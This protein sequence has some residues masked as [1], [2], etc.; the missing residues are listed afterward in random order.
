METTNIQEVLS[1]FDG[2][3]ECGDGK[4]M[5]CCPC[6][7]DRKQSLSIGRG[8]KGVV[9]KCHAG[10][11]THDI[12]ARV[13]IKPRD[14]FYDAE[15]KSSDRPQVVAIYNYP[16]GV[17]KLRKSDKSF[18]WR[19]PDG[20]GGYMY[21]RKGVKPSLYIAGEIS[22]AVAVVEG[23]KD[24]DSIHNVLGC[25]AVS[26]AD[27]AGPGKWRKEYTEQLRGCTALIFQDNDDVG[28]AYAQETAAALH[29]VAASVQLLD[30]ATV[31]PDIPEHGDVSDLIATFGAERAGE[32]IAQLI[33]DAPQWEPPKEPDKAKPGIMV[34]TAVDLQKAQLPPTVFLIA[35]ILPEGT[36]ILTAASKVGKS[37]MVLDMGLSIAEGADFMGHKTKQ[38]GVLYL[39]L[40]DSPSRLQDRM[41]KILGG[42]KAPEGF[43]FATAAPTLDNSLLD[44]LDATLQ[45]YP[46]IKLIIIDTL[47]KVRGR[48]LPRES[49]Y[50][51]DYREMGAI[52]THMDKKGVS[53]LA[54]HHNRKMKD[55]S[56][57]FNM[58]SGTNGIMGAADTVWTI[59]KDKR[60]DNEA[61]LHITGRDVAQSDTVITFDKSSWKWQAMGALD[62]L[63][64]QREQAAYEND[65]VVKTIRE[66]LKRH[67]EWKGTARELMD[68]GRKICKHPI[69]ISPQALGYSLRNLDGNLMDYD[70]IAH[71]R[72]KNGNAP[73][74]HYFYFRSWT[75]QAD[76]QEEIAL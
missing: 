68:E 61:T 60:T 33:Q 7:N 18:T 43:L 9:L 4:Y 28:K 62:L 14:L 47:Q 70:G 57:P 26:G 30:L 39:A 10:C 19:Q 40:E 1:H 27:G 35:G 13:G 71:D 69:A 38:S 11:D 16:G 25:N 59:I 49:G 44:Q 21:N 23:E 76:L 65:P 32:M 15:R 54:V 53:V 17:Q 67:G 36:T 55:E 66:L 42:R 63:T 22:G 24:A 51:L 8:E 29:G 2:V 58:I 45:Q 75:D 37:W 52:K 50:E 31:W 3:K 34:T 6:H 5:A 56:D 74:K 12:I 48:A 73:G 64:A 72:G 20:R 41:N 46:G